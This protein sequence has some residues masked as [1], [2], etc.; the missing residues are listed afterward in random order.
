MSV[1][2]L[3]VDLWNTVSEYRK[4]SHAGVSLSAQCQVYFEAEIGSKSECR[5][6]LASSRATVVPSSTHGRSLQDTSYR[7]S[8]GDSSPSR[9]KGCY[10]SDVCVKERGR[11]PR[12]G[13]VSSDGDHATRERDSERGGT[14]IS[15]GPSELL[16]RTEAGCLLMV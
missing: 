12:V 16:K 1:G 2:H 7:C 3:H 8:H 4:G 9:R 10:A 6:P 11:E 14:S 15:H 5:S 13:A